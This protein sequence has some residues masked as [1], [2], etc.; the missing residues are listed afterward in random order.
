MHATAHDRFWLDLHDPATAEA[1]RGQRLQ[2][3]IGVIYRPQTER[4]SHYFGARLPQQFDLYVHLD[5]TEALRPLEVS[6][7][8]SAGEPPETYPS[9]L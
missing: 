5:D 4:W 2:R 9:A 3:A 6:G 7:E 8:W 1:T